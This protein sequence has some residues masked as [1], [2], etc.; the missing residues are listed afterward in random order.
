V[1]Y[2]A[3][4]EITRLRVDLYSPDAIVRREPEL[5]KEIMNQ[6]LGIKDIKP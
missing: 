1:L 5:S 4:P 3:G 2:G 6:L